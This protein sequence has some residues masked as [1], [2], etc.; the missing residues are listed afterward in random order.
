M[1]PYKQSP[2]NSVMTN[3]CSLRKQVRGWQA[4]QHFHNDRLAAAATGKAERASA[5]MTKFPSTKINRKSPAASSAAVVGH[6]K[7]MRM[8]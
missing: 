7:I 3:K 4:L 1:D 5:Q 2:A 6:V 8:I